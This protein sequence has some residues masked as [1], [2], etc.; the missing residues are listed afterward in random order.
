MP[1]L[2]TS[3]R[4]SHVV[5]C[6]FCSIVGPFYSL[7]QRYHVMTPNQCP[8]SDKPPERWRTSKHGHVK[9]QEK[10]YAPLLSTP[11]YPLC[12]VLIVNTLLAC[13]VLHITR[14]K[15]QTNLCQSRTCPPLHIKILTDKP[16]QKMQYNLAI[17]LVD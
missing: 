5:I 6:V 13:V 9:I 14:P 8:P 16:N 10:T 15:F 7:F 2:P 11:S 17:T 1:N 3:R 4:V 12:T